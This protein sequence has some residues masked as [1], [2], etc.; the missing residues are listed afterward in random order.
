M[1]I[2]ARDRLAEL[3]EGKAV[4]GASSVRL[5]AEPDDLHLEVEGVGRVLFPVSPEQ[6][7]QLCQLGRRASF[8]RG[9]ETLT[10]PQVR[11]TWEI[12]RSLVRIEWSD[13]FKSMLDQVRDALGLPAGCELAADF[14][15]MLVYEPG[16][17]F[18]AHQDSEKDDAMVATLV[19]TLPAAYTGGSL[20]V[21][22]GG[23]TTTYRGSKVALT[24]VAFYADRRHEVRPVK[25]G[26][27]ITLTYNLLLRGDTS[28]LIAVDGE[29]VSELARCLGEH[30]SI[31]VTKPYRD[32]E[33]DPPSRL[34]YLLDHEYTARG[35]SWYR[36]KGSD[37][38]RA[39]LLRAA[40]DRSGCETVLALTDIQ[41]T[42]SAVEPEP[43]YGYRHRDEHLDD[44]DESGEAD[45]DAYELEELIDSSIRLSHWAGPAGAGL[46]EV[47]LIVDAAEVCATTPSADLRPYA[48]EY[49]GYMGN[50]GNTMDRWYRRAALVVWPHD[51][52]FR[53]RAEASPAWALD[54]LDA[55]V[56]AADLAGARAA[57]ATLAPLWDTAAARAERQPELL[58]KALQVARALDD[59][60]LAQLL[61]H[62]FRIESL[63]PTHMAPL[64]RLAGHYGAQWMDKS[65]RTWFGHGEPWAPAAGPDRPGWLA[66]V[67]RLCQA[68]Q[69]NGD[70]GT[71]TGRSLLEL[72]WGWLGETIRQGIAI[73]PPSYRDTRLGDLGQPLAAVLTAA[74]VTDAT[75][76]RNEVVE[77]VRQQDDTVVACL[78]PALRTAGTLPVDSRKSGGFDDLA[79]DCAARLRARLANPP[80]PDDDWSID[81]PDGCACELCGTLGGFVRDRARRTFEWPLAKERR[82]HIHSRIDTAELPVRHETRR[83]G[84]PYTLVLTK[85]RDLFTREKRARQRDEAD[86][87]WLDDQ[88]P[89]TV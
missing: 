39:S 75:A 41:E 21:E 56:R 82:R 87:E 24:L 13:T 59:A 40:A 15:S 62:P 12:P 11:D 45:P 32:V 35:L 47:S 66:S 54:D 33:A 19:V 88:W 76:L 74:A 83:T 65:L 22:H 37:A 53:N 14:H 73:R 61:L 31:P 70:A 72:S 4:P 64:A 52:A 7:R 63:N 16:Q 34:V 6:A 81:L 20:V 9:T 29:T 60:E 67:P 57:T 10:D 85:S 17:F 69:A 18:V 68:L 71:P 28:G 50:Y 78:M 42:W 43:R 46:E 80:R 3:L 27:R 5:R 30:F 51:R 38:H 58:G 77:F 55:R 49:E 86:L 79:A 23:E 36:L 26:H 48:S 44:E 8:G 1:T 25:S 89:P 84:R 2:A